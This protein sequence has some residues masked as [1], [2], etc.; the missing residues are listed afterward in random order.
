[1][2]A[3][4]HFTAALQHST[5]SPIDAS[6]SLSVLPAHQLLYVHERAKALQLERYFEEAIDD[7]SL[8]IAHNPT[9]ANAHFRRG[10]AYK[11]IG[12]VQAAASDLEAAKRLDPSNLALVVNYKEIRD[13]E[14]V[15][16]CPPGQEKLF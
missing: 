5:A 14:C 12:D 4:E 10:F 15:V 1:M 9:N 16:L 11:A 2:R 6:G 8:V 3:V 7:F 13:T